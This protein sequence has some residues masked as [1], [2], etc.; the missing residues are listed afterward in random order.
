[1]AKLSSALDSS[2]SSNALFKLNKILSIVSLDSPTELAIRF[3]R[4]TKLAIEPLP[5]CKSELLP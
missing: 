2:P 5:T 1:M 3:K 4:G